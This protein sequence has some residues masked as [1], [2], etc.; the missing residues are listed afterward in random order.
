ME[1]C[2]FSAPLEERFTSY[3]IRLYDEKQRKKKEN[4]NLQEK[5]IEL[6]FKLHTRPYGSE[7]RVDGQHST[8]Q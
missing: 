6:N 5:T 2:Y 1:A 4:I 3:E 7:I 8:D